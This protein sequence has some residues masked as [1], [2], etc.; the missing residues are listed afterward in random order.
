MRAVET[1]L[2]GSES[3]GNMLARMLLRTAFWLAG[4]AVLLFVPAGTLAGQRRGCSLRSGP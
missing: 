3:E 4:M 1:R 2:A